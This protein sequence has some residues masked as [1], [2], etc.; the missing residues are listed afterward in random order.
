MAENKP[1]APFW[2]PIT[3]DDLRRDLPGIELST[4]FVIRAN[5]PSVTGIYRMTPAEISGLVAG[6]QHDGYMPP[7]Q[8]ITKAITSL[9]NK[10]I[11]TRYPGNVFF[12]KDRWPLH[13]NPNNINHVRPA[14]RH[15]VK[16][17]IALADFISHFDI[18]PEKLAKVMSE[19]EEY[20]GRD[21]RFLISKTAH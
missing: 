20:C 12:M 10:G 11:I 2:N 8:E 21:E 6:F 4:L 19:L 16:F 3:P 9:E 15:V 1:N 5:C 17:P 18:H 14:L 7:L 13:N